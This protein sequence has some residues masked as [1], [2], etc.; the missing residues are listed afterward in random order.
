MVVLGCHG[1]EI[2]GLMD[3]Q[4]FWEWKS[5]K[6]GKGFDVYGDGGRGMVEKEMKMMNVNI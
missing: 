1:R 3:I 4:K 6:N 2:Y 5:R